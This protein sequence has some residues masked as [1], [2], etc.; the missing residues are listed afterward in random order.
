[1]NGG[2]AMRPAALLMSCATSVAV[3]GAAMAA[4]F[5]AREMMK[6]KRLADPQVSPDGAQVAYT[7]TEVEMPSGARNADIWVVSVGGG[8]PRRLTTDP[9][10]D[11]RPRWSPD[12]K[13]IGFLSSRDGTSQVYAVA[14]DG[15]T[16]KKLTAL[17]TGVDGFLWIDARTL[18]VVS[19][20]FPDCGPGWDE[21]CNNKKLDEPSAARAYDKLLY[22]H[23]DTWKEGRRTHLLVVPLDGGAARDLTPGPKELPFNLGGPDDYAV[24]PDGAE[25]CFSR[26]DD[27]QEAI[28]T[29][30]ELYAVAVAGGEV[31][32]IAGS[33]GYD[34]G[35]QYSPDGRTIAWRAQMRAGYE[36]DR[37]RLLVAD[38][39]T[40]AVRNL[41]EPFDRQVDA[42][43]WSADSKTLYFTAGDAGRTPVFSVPAAGGAVKK[44]VEGGTFGDVQAAA[45]GRFLVVTQ[46]TLTHPA[47]IYRVAVDGSGLAAVTRTNDAFLAGFALQKAESVTYTGAA[48]KSVQA[49]IVKPAGFDAAK[50]YPL[51]LIVHGGP[52]GAWED[53]WTYRWNAQVFANAGGFVVFAPNPRGSTGWGQEFVDDITGDWGGRAY[54]DVMKGTDFAEALP[55]VSKGRTVA[56]GA[57][58]GG[59]MINWIAGHTDRFKAL[60]SHDGLFDLRSAYGATEELWFPEW[61]FK[62]TPWDNP[63]MYERWSPANHVKDFKTPTLVVHGELDYR[64]PIEQGLA[65]FT[66]LQRRGVPSR[67]L[68][69]PDENH[70]VLKPQNSLRWYDEVLAWLRKWSGA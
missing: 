23:W 13:T 60:V 56:A 57:S 14:P 38:R 8:E 65:M 9:N 52:Q 21:A 42:F 35:C 18:L 43:A 25:V 29:N 27:E 22:R 46:A 24:A 48:G 33:P 32:K 67:L 17:A 2:F 20:V 12:G 28:S 5:D 69:F 49:W 4:T 59:Y 40:T 66:A 37:W 34:G 64:V 26:K 3:T 45:G 44:V 61:E 11:T 31:R 39:K 16:A 70:W 47:E 10:S 41:T 68:V 58:Y 55:Y 51:L 36:S 53:A 54:E 1:M 19:D 50:K 7:A 62:G 15:G 6:L 63:E 30:A